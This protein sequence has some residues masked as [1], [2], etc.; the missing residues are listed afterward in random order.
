MLKRI[1][2]TFAALV[3]L[4]ALAL[5]GSAIAA[6]Q[7]HKASHPKHHAI[8]SARF[9]AATSSAE[10]PGTEADGPGGLNVQSGDQTT[11]DN[12]AAN[13]NE[14]GSESSAEAPSSQADGP[15]GHQ[16]PPGANGNS[17]QQGQN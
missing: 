15:G 5:G 8:R 1:T 4:G 17:Q 14:S 6:A 2:T 12:G 11:P 10:G 13:A 7:Q 3:A 9:T 16:D